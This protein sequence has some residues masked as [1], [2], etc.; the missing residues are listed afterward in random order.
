MVK[1]DITV[2][3]DKAERWMEIMESLEDDLGYEPSRPE[4]LELLMANFNPGDSTY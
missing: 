2:R 4:A 3:S 1:I